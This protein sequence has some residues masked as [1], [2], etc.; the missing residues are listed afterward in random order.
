MAHIELGN[1]LPGI[2]GLLKYNPATAYPLLLLAETLLQGNSTLSKGEREIIATV[3]SGKND[4]QFCQLSHGAAAAHHLKIGL[5]DIEKIKSAPNDSAYLSPKMKALLIIAGQVQTGGKNVSTTAIDD[6]KKCGATDM[7]IHDT[8]LIAAA[9][10]M[11]NRYVDG[12]G[13]E[14]E[15]S[16]ETYLTASARMAQ[17]GYLRKE[18]LTMLGIDTEK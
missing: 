6:A 8:V 18:N 17:E 13:T 10:C 7:E 3:T 4:C 16:A 14:S 11:F 9:F 2:R 1:P 5:N 15:S 12:L